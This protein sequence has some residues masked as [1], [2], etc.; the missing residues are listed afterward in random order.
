MM[1]VSVAPGRR[2]RR[3]RQQ[4]RGDDGAAARLVPGA[5]G[6]ARHRARG[7]EG[8][9]VGRPGRRRA[10]AHRPVRLRPADDDGPGVAADVAPALLQPG[11]DERAGAAVPALPD[12][13]PHA[14]PV[15]DGAAARKARDW[16]WRCCPTT[17]RS[18]SASSATTTC[19]GTSTSSR[20]TCATRSPS[21]P[22]R[23]ASSCSEPPEPVARMRDRLA[24]CARELGLEVR[25]PAPRSLHAHRQGRRR[26]PSAAR[27]PRSRSRSCSWP[28]AI[29]VLCV[30]SGPPPDRHR[31]ARRRPRRRGGA[32][33]G[34][35]G[36]ARG[37]RLR[38]RR[39]A[40]V[41]PRPARPVRRGAA[42]AR[43]RLGRRRRPAQPV[44]GRSARAGATASRR[45]WSPSARRRLARRTSAPRRILY[46]GRKTPFAARTDHR[47]H[48]TNAQWRSHP[49]ESRRSG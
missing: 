43:A 35:R 5:G 20:R 45:A 12:G 8:P 19:S 27:S 10:G 48:G 32:P 39:R 29:P 15:P 3:A 2:A 1:P 41:R 21:W 24:E 11:R 30:A 18:T 14:R 47:R 25:G 31:Q 38:H 26:A 6:A 23:P 40:A 9:Q 33:G 4:G 17:G 44:R 13:P 36:G 42:R 34:R 49:G 46:T 22:T 7:A 37:H 16:A 28:T